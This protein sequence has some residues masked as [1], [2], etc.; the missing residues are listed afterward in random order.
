[1]RPR[2]ST[3]G[4][5]RPSVR[6]PF[7][8]KSNYNKINA[9]NTWGR[10]VSRMDLVNCP[11]ASRLAA[12]NNHCYHITSASYTTDARATTAAIHQKWL[13]PIWCCYYAVSQSRHHVTIQSCHHAIY[14]MLT[15]WAS[16]LVSTCIRCWCLHFVW[17]IERT[18]MLHAAYHPLEL[19]VLR[20]MIRDWGGMR[21]FPNT[22]VTGR[23]KA[24]RRKPLF[25]KMPKW[26]WIFSVRNQMSTKS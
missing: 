2:I 7:V 23:A 15:V 18:F 13:L 5:V 10:I 26:R 16:F 22:A 9:I 24:S 3:R 14:A 11:L 12:Q 21:C 8:E 20:Y 6:H 4:S 25:T 1:M 17:Y 19:N